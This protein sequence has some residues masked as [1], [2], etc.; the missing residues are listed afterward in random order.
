MKYSRLSI[1]P[2]IFL[3]FVGLFGA[4]IRLIP[5]TNIFFEYEHILHSHSHVAFQGWVFLSFYLIYCQLF[6]PKDLV[7]KKVYKILFVAFIVNITGILVSFLWQ[8]YAFYSILF[9]SLFQL[10]CYY[11]IYRFF[12]DSKT[13]T[14][15]NQNDI[16][17]KFAKWSLIFLM[18]STIGPWVVGVLSAKGLKGSEWFNSAVYFFL[19]F[20]YNGFFTLAIFS[21]LF[22]YLEKLPNFNYKTGSLFF[23]LTT[24]SVIPAYF[25]SLLGM[26]FKDYIEWFAHFS[27]VLLFVSLFPLAQL[28]IVYL[29]QYSIKNRL[30]K[31][32]AFI[33]VAS[34][35]LK[36]IIQFLS[37]IPPLQILGLHNHFVVIAFL[38][39]V[40]IGTITL[41][42]FAFFLANNWWQ[43]SSKLTQTGISLFIIAFIISEFL[44]ISLGFLHTIALLK[45]L[46]LVSFI[47]FLGIALVLLNELILVCTAKP[48]K[49]H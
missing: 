33:I 21:V 40:F 1:I 22:K 38:H 7:N 36:I 2:L 20:Q 27:S 16:S 37:I 28:L 34:Y 43:S 31:I 46:A 24:L 19:H 45:L 4:L 44:I 49:L 3:F 48:D 13:N 39:L 35:F 14:L 29:Q 30:I 10:F 42:I 47:M 9:S 25:V 11:F 32:L 23:K 15:L 41:F 26:S 12:K 18:L 17:L 6:I 8:G 5:F